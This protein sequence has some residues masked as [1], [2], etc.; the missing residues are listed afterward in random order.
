MVKLF[1]TN[2]VVRDD[3]YGLRV[4]DKSLEDIITVAL[5]VRANSSVYPD[6]KPFMSNCCNITVIIDPQ[7][8]TTHIEVNDDEYHSVEQ[9]EEDRDEQF[10][11]A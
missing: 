1:F 7:P 5:G 4:N 2:A 9:L 6:V 11:N 10:K 8:V 3:G